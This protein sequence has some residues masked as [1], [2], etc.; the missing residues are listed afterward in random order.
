MWP[1]ILGLI[2]S[3]APA[4]VWPCAFVIGVIGYN[5]ET[6]FRTPIELPNQPSTLD[7]RNE[8]LLSE[9]EG[10]DMTQVDRITDK[11]FVPKTIFEKNLDNKES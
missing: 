6:I 10:K 3:Y 1:V 7:R 2:R 8:R 5:F 11:K 9:S 4:V